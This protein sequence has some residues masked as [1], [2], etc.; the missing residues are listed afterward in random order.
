MYG[1]FPTLLIHSLIHLAAVSS[2][3]LYEDASLKIS[4]GHFARVPCH[5]IRPLICFK[6]ADCNFTSL[7]LY[8]SCGLSQDHFSFFE[9]SIY[10]AESRPSLTR[11]E[12]S[13][14]FFFWHDLFSTF[15]EED[16]LRMWMTEW[17]ESFSSPCGPLGRRVA[18]SSNVLRQTCSAPLNAYKHGGEKIADT[19]CLRSFRLNCPVR[20]EESPLNICRFQTRSPNS[21]RVFFLGSAMT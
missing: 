11:L 1:I 2:N 18:P 17:R 12:S 16:N 19:F 15:W 20:E 4:Y 13:S 6:T 14:Y 10:W 7:P 9:V 8:W 3:R 5:R 21:G